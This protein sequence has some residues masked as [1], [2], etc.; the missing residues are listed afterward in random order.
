MKKMIVL[1]LVMLSFL[2]V[3]VL[4]RTGADPHFVLE[5]EPVAAEAEQISESA[6]SRRAATSALRTTHPAQSIHAMLLAAVEAETG[7]DRRNEALG[8]AAECVSDVDLPAM[9]D[10]LALDASPKAAEMSLLLVRRWAESDA[11]A[12]AAWTLQLPEN[13]VWRAA[14]ERVAIA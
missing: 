12:A 7:A 2:L 9:L 5:D 14:L 4:R 6:P 13:P 8:R 3:V 1:G 10:S 11:P